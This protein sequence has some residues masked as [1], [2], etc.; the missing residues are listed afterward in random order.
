MI[1]DHTLES[2]HSLI[3]SFGFAFE[4][5]KAE[6]KKGRNFRIQVF[7][8]IAATALGIVLKISRVEWLVLIL[9]ISLVIILEL[10]NTATEQI[11][12]IISPEIRSEAKIAKDVSA[13]AVLVASIA[14]TL[15][16]VLIFLPKIL[17]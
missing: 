10:I 3:K 17:S 1:E 16:G 15:A 4:G 6:F 14:A 13:G 7:S 8:G 5:I 2:K 12:N 11:V 9:V